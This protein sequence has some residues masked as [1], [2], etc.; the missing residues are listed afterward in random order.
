[1]LQALHEFCPKIEVDE[2]FVRDNSIQSPLDQSVKIVSVSEIVDSI[3]SCQRFAYDT[4]NQLVE[5][6]TLLHFELFAN[7]GEVILRELFAGDESNVK[8]ESLAPVTDRA[9]SD[10]DKYMRLLDISMFRL[11]TA[12]DT[13]PPGETHKLLR[14]FEFQENLSVSP[15]PVPG[16]LQ[17][18]KLYAFS[19][20]AGATDFVC[21]GMCPTVAVTLQFIRIYQGT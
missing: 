2:Y 10:T 1:M 8:N 19:S 20:I 13:A 12:L 4:T 21:G 11:E 7:L 16:I 14:V 17:T 15:K 3:I 9:H 5:I 6:N 18:T